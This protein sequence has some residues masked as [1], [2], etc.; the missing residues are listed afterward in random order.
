MLATRR[1]EGR[2]G[3]RA[4]R[5]GERDE[6]RGMRRKRRERASEGPEVSLPSCHS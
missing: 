5:E 6:T 1:D 2:H 3:K 4:A